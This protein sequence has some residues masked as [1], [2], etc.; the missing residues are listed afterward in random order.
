MG[1]VVH[2]VSD[3]GVLLDDV[4]IR[5]EDGRVLSV[6]NCPVDDVIERRQ[7]VGPSAKS[8]AGSIEAQFAYM[9]HHLAQIRIGRWIVIWKK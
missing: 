9:W 3:L 4:T 2:E 8:F 6:G 5:P 1:V 7:N